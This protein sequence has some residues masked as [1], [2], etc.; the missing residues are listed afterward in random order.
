MPDFVN[1]RRAGIARALTTAARPTLLFVVAYAF[2]TTPHEAFH[3]LTAYLLGFNSTIYQMWVNPDQA[4]A[5]PSELATIAA[6]APIFSLTAGV[7][8]LLIYTSRFR[9]RPS[10]LL[11]LMLAFVG[12]VCFLAP[13]AGSTFGGDFHTTFEFLAAPRWIS[14]IVSVVG[15]LALI[16][17]TFLMGHELAGWVPPQFGP[18]GTVI[19]AAVAPAVAGTLLIVFL[20]WPLPR[21]LILS[22]M[23][24]AGFWLPTMI[25]AALGFARPRPQR[26][27]AAFTW[28]DAVVGVTAIV[29]IRVFATGV[30]LAH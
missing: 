6:A 5:T 27:L 29:M 9:L 7:V 22:T 26:E 3:A 17:F 8:C 25:G 12:I 20:Y 11:F 28:Q 21:S 16:A 13:M 2:N 23:S 18:A 1:A 15:W 24:G 30:R 4:S 14:A 10:G 19:S